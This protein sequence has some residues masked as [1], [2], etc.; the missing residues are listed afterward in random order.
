MFKKILITLGLVLLSVSPLYAFSDVQS[1]D[2]QATAIFY[3]RDQGIINGYPDGTYQPEKA[4]NR[5]ELTKIVLL[6]LDLPLQEFDECFPDVKAEDWFAKYVCTAKSLGWIK[7]YDDG[8]FK[9]DQTINH[10]EAMKIMAKAGEWA[11]EDGEAS[12]GDVPADEWYT[13]YVVTAENFNFLPFS[14][15][16]EPGAEMTRGDFAEIYYRIVVTEERGD[17][18][19]ISIEEENDVTDTDVDLD[20]LEVKD[21]VAASGSTFEVDTFPGMDLDVEFPNVMMENE[22]YY[23]EGELDKSAETMYVLLFPK[24]HDEDMEVS[25]FALDGKSFSVPVYFKDKGDYYVGLTSDASKDVT[26]ANIEVVNE[27]S[28]DSTLALATKM[29]GID[30]A[31][32]DDLTKMNYE[33]NDY[34]KKIIVKENSNELTYFSRQNRGNIGLRFKDFE[35]FT[36]GMATYY[37]ETATFDIAREVRSPWIKSSEHNFEIT[38]HHY[39]EIDETLSSVNVPDFYTAGSKITISASTP[40]PL[41]SELSVIRPDGFVDQYENNF[42]IGANSNFSMNFQTENAGGTY[43]V[44]VNHLT[45][46]AA[47]NHPVYESGKIPLVPDF[48]D[49]NPLVL[50][51]STFNESADVDQLFAL[52]N[53]SRTE[54]GLLTVRIDDDLNALAKAHGEDMVAKSYFAHNNLEGETPDMRAVKAGLN[55]YVGEN[56]ANSVSTEY[57]HEALMRSAIHR[58]NI[59]T[60]DWTKVGIGVVQTSEG[61]YYAVEEFS[62]DIAYYYNELIDDVNS[63]A[64]VTSTLEDDLSLFAKNWNDTMI[65]NEFFDTTY[66]GGSISDNIG[67]LSYGGYRFVILAGIGLD[68]FK[69]SINT[70]DEWTHYGLDVQFDSK[71]WQKLLDPNSND[72]NLIKVTI[73]YAK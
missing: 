15:N 71:A 60:K 13:A 35:G 46:I 52:V 23:F 70:N 17:D 67:D 18:K 4:L 25:K 10:A 63:K 40:T 30:V 41:N 65:E 69:E 9:G 42:T 3:L 19:Y 2:D 51:D 50:N 49:L 1:T 20:G 16:F 59:L 53:Q 73:V 33:K 58:K 11:L 68:K 48:F 62:T 14:G 37:I 31:F 66:S 47:I 54:Y 22:V 7:G 57:N 32:A 24:G 38:T 43:I 29:S 21:E 55:M 27:F 39:S 6:S 36:E 34:L 5:A 44:E 45:G 61:Q 8:T 64:T 56:L 12:F 26:I 72:L 28:E